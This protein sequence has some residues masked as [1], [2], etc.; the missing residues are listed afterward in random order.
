M[1]HGT[2]S[3]VAE[4]KSRISGV[5]TPVAER[6][7]LELDAFGQQLT[8]GSGKAG[9]LTLSSAF[10]TGLEP[11]PITPTAA[12]PPWVFLS[13]VVRNVLSTS[14]REVYA[15]KTIVVAPSILLG[16]LSRF[17]LPEL[18]PIHVLPE[19]N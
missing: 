14:T 1:K 13:G 10:S 18:I 11:A 4:L 9:R 2:S 15:G 17:A 12:S 3:S 6:L 8:G 19:H 16:K 5:L 7:D